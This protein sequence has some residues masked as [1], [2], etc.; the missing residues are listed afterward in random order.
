[1]SACVKL[2]TGELLDVESD[3]GDDFGGPAV[4]RFEV[5]DHR[6]LAAVVE[7]DDEHVD[8]APAQPQ[9]GHQLGQQAHLRLRE[10]GLCPQTNQNLATFFGTCVRMC[11]HQAPRIAGLP[12]D[13]RLNNHLDRGRW[14]RL[15]PLVQSILVRVNK[16]ICY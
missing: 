16:K 8:L 6:G 7:A 9:H 4:V 1:M 2:N 5:V 10:C 14:G 12:S 11:D 15:A 3:R 13:R